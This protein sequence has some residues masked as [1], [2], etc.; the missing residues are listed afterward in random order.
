[1]QIIIDDKPAA[2]N[3]VVADGENRVSEPYIVLSAW[4]RPA[5]YLYVPPKNATGGRDGRFQFAG[6]APGDYRIFAVSQT[7]RD[8]LDEPGVLDRLLAAA[9]KISLDPRGSQNVTLKL[10]DLGR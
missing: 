8:K 4:P 7:D 5:D 10:T 2:I 6:L 1:M 3:G 9:E